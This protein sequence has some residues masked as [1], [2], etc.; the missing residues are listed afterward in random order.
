MVM[1]K[2][3]ETNL[4]NLA[5]GN[6]S[7]EFVQYGSIHYDLFNKYQECQQYCELHCPKE[8]NRLFWATA[9]EGFQRVQTNGQ[10]P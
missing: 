2:T 4:S 9:I 5:S 3:D 10:T 1:A 7:E 8:N 6:F